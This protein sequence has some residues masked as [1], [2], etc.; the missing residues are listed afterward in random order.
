MVK[1]KSGLK[2]QGFKGDEPLG[3]EP[4]DG[5]IPRQG[6]FA[7]TI[8]QVAIREASTGTIFYNVL[9]RL[10]DQNKPHKQQYKGYGHFDKVFI[11]DADFTKQR[12]AQFLRTV[13]GK[14]PDNVEIIT[15]HEAITEGGKVTRIGGK[16]PNGL[17]VKLSLLPGE[18]Y[19]GVM[20]PRV[21]D[22]SPWPEDEE[23]PESDV[24]D[25]EDADD[26]DDADEEAGDDEYDERAEALDELKKPALRRIAKELG[27]KL[28]TATSEED[29]RAAILDAEFPDEE[30]GGEED[31]DEDDPEGERA[32]ELSTMERPALRTIAKGLGIRVLKSHEDEDLR[33]L[34]IAKEFENSGEDDDEPPF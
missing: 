16:A 21:A 18:V 6:V 7:A 27:L 23:W 14:D 28:P 10:G 3:F 15:D 26:A 25:E 24:V 8:Q 4:Y 5:E 32:E 1:L 30:E 11:G 20:T 22:V 19:M 33:E 34:I 12:L 31:D 2:G 17:R 9:Y 13:S 29:T